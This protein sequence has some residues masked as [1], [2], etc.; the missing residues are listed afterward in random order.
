MP[1]HLLSH[2]VTSRKRGVRVLP[3]HVRRIFGKAAASVCGVRAQNRHARH[4][5][6]KTIVEDIPHRTFGKQG[7]RIAAK[8]RIASRLSSR[9]QRLIERRIALILR[10]TGTVP[11]GQRNGRVH[12]AGSN[13]VDDRGRDRVREG[14]HQAEAGADEAVLDSREGRRGR[15]GNAEITPLRRQCCRVPGIVDIPEPELQ[16][17]SQVVVDAK[18]L[19]PPIGGRRNRS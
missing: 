14:R 13:T 3:W 16:F 19:L 6:A 17:L 2:I 8:S 11:V 1:A 9:D 7:S 15:V 5:A 12:I 4:L 18:Q 10:S